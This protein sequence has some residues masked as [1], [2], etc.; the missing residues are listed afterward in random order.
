M[1][2]AFLVF[3]GYGEFNQ[4]GI[5]FGEIIYHLLQ[6]QGDVVFFFDEANRPAR[7]DN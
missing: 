6:V 4:D 7:L 1:L 3:D 2:A 5:V